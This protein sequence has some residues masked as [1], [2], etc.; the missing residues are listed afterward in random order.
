M[1][2]CPRCSPPALNAVKTV[3]TSPPKKTP[4]KKNTKN[5]PKIGQNRYRSARHRRRGR[6]QGDGGAQRG[7]RGGR[8]D[9][10]RGI[11][12][13]GRGA[14]LVRG[15]VPDAGAGSAVSRVSRVLPPYIGAGFGGEAAALRV[16]PAV[17]R[18]VL[19]GAAVVGVGGRGQ[20]PHG[21]ALD[22]P[23]V[24]APAVPVKQRGK[25]QINQ[26]QRPKRGTDQH[27][28]ADIIAQNR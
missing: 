20:G 13:H 17:V 7:G 16:G 24:A 4:Q 11:G 25:S 23:A 9:R 12:G 8:A 5:R 22:L 3:N 15:G 19:A 18:V 6:A 2:G 10:Y 26:L 1:C 14:G 27:D 21:R 28:V